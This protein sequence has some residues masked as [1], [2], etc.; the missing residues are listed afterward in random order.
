MEYCRA[1]TKKELLC[2]RKACKDSVY[3]SQHIPEDY[4][5]KFRYSINSELVTDYM[6]IL[7]EDILHNIY[8][9]YFSNHVL[10]EIRYYDP[11]GDFSRVENPRINIPAVTRDYALVSKH[12]LWHFFRR[13]RDINS[14]SS[15]YSVLFYDRKFYSLFAPHYTYGFR[16]INMDIFDTNMRT[17]EYIANNGW[18]DYIMN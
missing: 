10:E 1:I 14:D 12:N 5:S 15:N 3:C 11:Q 9:M 17:I 6:K 4:S 13:N 7:P 18:F 2:K 8:K 16:Y